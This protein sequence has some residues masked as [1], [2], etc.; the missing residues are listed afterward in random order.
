MNTKIVKQTFAIDKPQEVKQ[1]ALVLTKYIKD[2][3]LSANI[4][5]HEYVMVEGWQFAGGLMGLFPQIKEVKEVST[6][7]WMAVAEITDRKTDKVV[8]TGYAICSKEE[9]KKKS[10]DE[11]A[12]LSMAQTRAI[13]KAYRNLIGWVIKMS[14]YEAM[15][16]EEMK[17][18]VVDEQRK[19]TA[20]KKTMDIKDL[21]T[22]DQAKN[23][24]LRVERTTADKLSDEQKAK[25][26]A[27]VDAR[28]KELENNAQPT[29]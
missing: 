6:G 10:F 7:K 20:F 29:K 19:E 15:P 4:A 23:Y 24:R 2:N 14:G 26:F 3:H 17:T 22:A 16:A 18:I 27:K 21:T 13:G 5:G 9:A 1:M 8:S 12:I 25:I 28:I 11:Y